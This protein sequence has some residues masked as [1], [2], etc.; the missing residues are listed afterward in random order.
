LASNKHISGDAVRI[1]S[2][3]LKQQKFLDPK[4]RRSKKAS[5]KTRA[6]DEEWDLGARDIKSDPEDGGTVS[7]MI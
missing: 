3:I 5:T 7:K 6:K 1:A 4:K 2:A